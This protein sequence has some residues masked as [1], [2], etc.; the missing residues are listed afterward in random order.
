MSGGVI[1]I[2]FTLLRK[3]S[4]QEISPNRQSHLQSMIEVSSIFARNSVASE[5]PNIH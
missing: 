4:N 5:L 1:V 3:L 2:V